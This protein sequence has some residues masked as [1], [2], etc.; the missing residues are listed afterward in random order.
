M[1]A[2]MERARSVVRLPR[3]SKYL[4]SR[5]M[6][7]SAAVHAGVATLLWKNAQEKKAGWQVL[8]AM[9]VA[10]T[11]VVTSFFMVLPFLLVVQYSSRVQGPP[12]SEDFLVSLR[13][14]G[15]KVQQDPFWL[16]HKAQKLGQHLIPK[17]FI[18]LF[19]YGFVRQGGAPAFK[20]VQGGVF[21]AAYLL[22]IYETPMSKARG[23]EGMENADLDECAHF[24]FREARQYGPFSLFEGNYY[25]FAQLFWQNFIMFNTLEFA[26]D[27]L[28]DGLWSSAFTS[29][30]AIVVCS[31]FSPFFRR[32]VMVFYHSPLRLS[33]ASILEVETAKDGTARYR[34]DWDAIQTCKF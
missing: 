8:V 30:L 26:T 31:F 32:F 12:S 34:L 18:N 9:G 13:R 3:P 33:L 4:V 14:L 21:T 19:V 24:L 5:E 15:E 29:V 1:L 17:H 27:W 2:G 10:V 11:A 20:R 7:M 6:V 25:V 16:I 23:R 28:G 22:T